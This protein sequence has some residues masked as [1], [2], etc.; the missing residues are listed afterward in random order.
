MRTEIIEYLDDQNLG[1]F[2]L[3]R[4]LPWSSS[5]E[6]L[7]TK[8]AK[9]IY[10]DKTQYSTDPLIATLD[11]LNITNTIFTV[12]LFFSNDAKQLP[13]SYDDLITTLRS[14]KDT[15]TITGVSRRDVVVSSAFEEDVLVT[16]LEYRFT[17]LT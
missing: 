17:K 12:R 3:S 16:E 5:G 8:N 1:G 13:P 9:K 15:S 11:G 7:Y 4:E 14:A 6:P 10:V 2:L